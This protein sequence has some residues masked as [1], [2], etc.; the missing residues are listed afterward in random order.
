MHPLAVMTA[1]MFTK[2]I[3]ASRNR[4]IAPIFLQA[5]LTRQRGKICVYRSVNERGACAFFAI[6]DTHSQDSNSVELSPLISHRN[7]P[8]TLVWPLT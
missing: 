2:D 6:C 5:L 1:R 4:A 8:H 3:S 7:L